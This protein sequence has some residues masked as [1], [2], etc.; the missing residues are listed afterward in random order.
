MLT[1]L[2]GLDVG[3]APVMIPNLTHV[4][5]NASIPSRTMLRLL[6]ERRG[7]PPLY[8]IFGW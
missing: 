1:Y 6:L 7:I 5:I 2:P 4:G 8:S 3:S